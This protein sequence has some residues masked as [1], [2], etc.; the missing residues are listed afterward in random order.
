MC[1]LPGPDVLP[2]STAAIVFATSNENTIE[3]TIPYG[4]H[5]YFTTGSADR[6]QPT[7]FGL[8][9]TA[10]FPE[11]GVVVP[12]ES[13]ETS[14][15]WVLGD[16]SATGTTS[17][18]LCV[19]PC[20]NSE[21]GGN[22]QCIVGTC[23]CDSGFI[24]AGCEQDLHLIV[25]TV[26]CMI[27]HFDNS[28][29]FQ[30][31]VVNSNDMEIVLPVGPTNSFAPG[32]ANN[33]QPTIFPAGSSQTF[34]FVSREASVTWTIGANTATSDTNSAQCDLPCPGD[35][36][37]HGFCDGGNCVCQ[38]GWTTEDCNTVAPLLTKVI[39][40]LQCV[41]HLC[42]SCVYS[43]VFSYINNNEDSVDIPV[44][45]WNTFTPAPAARG[46][47]TTFA[48]GASNSV[49]KVELGID[50]LVWQLGS[51]YITASALSPIC[52]L[53]C[54]MD[55]SGRGSCDTVTGTCACDAGWA[56]EDCASNVQINFIT[57][58]VQC[59]E[60]QNDG[61]Y[62]A[63]F[64]Y[65][66]TLDYAVYQSVGDL[67][68]LLP[69]S[70]NAPIT[71]VFQPG[72]HGAAGDFLTENVFAAS[73]Y[74]MNKLKWMVGE[75]T[76]VA[77]TSSPVCPYR[78]PISPLLDCVE[79]DDEETTITAHFGWF[80]PNSVP[81]IVAV[82]EQNSFTPAPADRGQGTVFSAGQTLPYP[83]TTFTV[84]FPFADVLTWT[85]TTHTVAASRYSAP[86]VWRPTAPFALSAIL[87]NQLTSFTT[88]FD[89]PTNLAGATG[90]NVAG[91]CADV[92]ASN[93]A[94]LLGA[95]AQCTWISSSQVRTTFGTGFTAT[96]GTELHFSPLILDASGTSK[97]LNNSVP[98][99]MGP[100]PQQPM[101]A[102]SAP[103]TALTCHTF[104]L[105]G[106]AS[107]AGGPITYAWSL[108]NGADVH[109]ATTQ[110]A[111]QADKDVIS[112][113]NL[114]PGAYT[115][116]LTV[117]D[118][119]GQ[120]SSAQKSLQVNSG[121]NSF[122]ITL[123]KPHSDSL[124][125]GVSPTYAVL[126][127]VAFPCA[128]DGSSLVDFSWTITP[129]LSGSVIS[130][131]SQL[132]IP[133]T[134][135][136]PQ[137]YTLMV[138]VSLR[139]NPNIASTASV[140][141]VVN[142][143]AIIPS[144][145]GGGSMAVTAPIS[146]GATVLNPNGPSVTTYA[147]SCTDS[148]NNPCMTRLNV[149]LVLAPTSIITIP[150]DTLWAGEYHFSVLVSASGQ[151]VSA[152]TNVLLT[153][154]GATVSIAPVDNNIEPSS[155]LLVSAS[156]VSSS[157]S[158]IHFVWSFDTT[159]G[160]SGSLGN[161]LLAPS[162]CYPAG[163]NSED[164]LIAATCLPYGTTFALRLTVTQDGV[165]TSAVVTFKTTSV[166][167]AGA[168]RATQG[169]GPTLYSFRATG[170]GG[171]SSVTY[172]YSYAFRSAPSVQ[173]M[174]STGPGATNQGPFLLPVGQLRIFVVTSTGGSAYLDL[175]VAMPLKRALVTS[176]DVGAAI[177]VVRN[178]ISSGMYIV[179]MG[180]IMQAVNMLTQATSLSDTQQTTFRLQLVDQLRIVVTGYQSHREV[181]SALYTMLY[182]I[183]YSHE[184]SALFNAVINLVSQI[185]VI[186]ANTDPSA[187]T[188]FQRQ[189]GVSA[190]VLTPTEC[191]ALAHVAGVITTSSRS[192]VS[193]RA[194][195]R[196]YLLRISQN[197]VATMVLGQT[198]N[199]ISS[200][201]HEHHVTIVRGNAIGGIMIGN[202]R[203]PRS[204]T[205]TESSTVIVQQISY[206]RQPHTSDGVL[207]NV[208][209]LSV[210]DG[211][212][213]AELTVEGLTDQI[214]VA[215]QITVATPSARIQ[216]AYF[217]TTTQQ[218]LT[219]GLTTT[220]YD[221]SVTC[222]TS[223]LTDF[224]L[225]DVPV[226]VEPMPVGILAAILSGAGVVVVAAV[227]ILAVCLRIR[228]KNQAT[229][230]VMQQQTELRVA[231]AAL[232]AQQEA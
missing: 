188:Q 30:F 154:A 217:D 72:T 120:M 16:S 117:Y 76:A 207:S 155:Q 103:A 84:S 91:S 22:G 167:P 53:A 195:G 32:L 214:T 148:S 78:V 44:G 8:G 212:S 90:L 220:R 70:A 25:P 47:P 131:T 232:L 136:T 203:L 128:A 221:T 186:V 26:G 168:I 31:T 29:T 179:A 80:N 228:S 139:S 54:P 150:G 138:T 166:A 19:V 71:T 15:T 97:H 74:G 59:V 4:I 204:F 61:S 14:L 225:V 161:I 196:S 55:C 2:G 50:Q 230:A 60:L 110:L 159:S 105:D 83:N 39:P 67:N 183:M 99:Q 64:G 210:H 101:A 48:P 35:C 1:R 73:F 153:S 200:V 68:T 223:H 77:S 87:S 10:S 75:Q 125:L 132:I 51:N 129:A 177:Q 93:T 140:M 162:F 218:Y 104:S 122:A 184:S 24:G 98:L 165:T 169:S 216:C 115:F 124:T 182:N 130:A 89:I 37:G 108:I 142:A 173:V 133:T 62:L 57:P 9:E 12:F 3:Y 147:W 6:E 85:L 158:P 42:P 211:A 191:Q 145:T 180:D 205:I 92:F 198:P 156:V 49:F 215:I 157:S 194:T 176:S 164:L 114:A 187:L 102:I 18:P 144:I 178:D 146:L 86:C 219:T 13:S 121:L 112:F 134:L 33:G 143:G 202:F 27:E 175:D 127:S 199:T 58:T 222:G 56:G 126:A 206:K 82:G 111:P 197:T 65:I 46:Q 170:F 229:S 137:T 171:G 21:C 45:V 192:T 38:D 119:F 181:V 135:L 52:P 79:I 149:P 185:D 116:G 20:P 193:Q 88:T 107:S 163:I 96:I 109:G 40:T 66:N 160:G 226:P 95:G 41:E 63:Y 141:L 174:L 190:N 227:I 17:T 209:S 43:A 152:S 94:S 5:N 224:A 36:N 172:T 231:K 7:V 208:H 213:G 123:D 113:I 151:S 201:Y 100:N 28:R 189:S 23:I 34:S 11:G 106:G 81:A 69:A 118:N